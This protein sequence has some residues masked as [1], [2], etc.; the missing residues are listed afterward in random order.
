MPSLMDDFFPSKWLRGDDLRGPTAA[1]IIEIRKELVGK[2]RAEKAVLYLHNLKPLIV[3]RDNGERLLHAMGT[4]DYTLFPGKRI[5]LTV[6]DRE[7]EGKQ[8]RV[9]VIGRESPAPRRKP[10]PPPPPP[11]ADDEDGE[12]EEA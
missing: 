7:W 9:V 4:G 6:E 10:E 11:P 1:T 8:I 12:W 5:A 3:N 2:E